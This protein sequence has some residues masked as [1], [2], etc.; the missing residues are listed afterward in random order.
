MERKKNSNTNGGH[1]LK[2]RGERFYN[3]PDALGKTGT[4]HGMSDGVKYYINSCT[5]ELK[6][7]LETVNDL[8]VRLKDH[9]RKDYKDVKETI[10]VIQKAKKVFEEKLE[11][12]DGFV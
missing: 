2:D 8:E 7:L 10:A 5:A 9:P 11:I 4:F 6:E 3:K 12:I 1:F